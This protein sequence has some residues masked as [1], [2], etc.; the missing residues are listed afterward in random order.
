MTASQLPGSHPKP[1][2]A[3]QPCLGLHPVPLSFCTPPPLLLP[4]HCPSLAWD[5][6]F[7]AK[8]KEPGEVPAAGW[9][10]RKGPRPSS[11]SFKRLPAGPVHGTEFHVRF[12]LN[13]GFLL[14]VRKSLQASKAGS[15]PK[16]LLPSRQAS[17]LNMGAQQRWIPA[18]LPCCQ[19]AD[20]YSITVSTRERN[21]LFRLNQLNSPP[22]SHV[23][24]IASAALL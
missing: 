12:C 2:W 24:W 22:V 18:S 21:G 16:Q 19:L 11:M 13:K 15:N 17:N 7:P 5:S 9:S 20:I 1:L 10:G 23:S 4:G 14:T 3:Q 8:P 6:G